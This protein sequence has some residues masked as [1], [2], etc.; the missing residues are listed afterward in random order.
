MVARPPVE[1]LQFL[2]TDSDAATQA[3][4]SFV[5]RGTALELGCSSWAG[6]CS[7]RGVPLKSTLRL[8]LEAGVEYTLQMY[9]RTGATKAAVLPYF[10]PDAP[11]TRSELASPGRPRSN[12][13]ARR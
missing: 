13:S 7:W 6:S 2:A 3:Y 4:S 8:P 12:I 5:P 10:L 11:V 1:Q 9:V